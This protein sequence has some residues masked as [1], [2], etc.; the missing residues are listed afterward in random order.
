MTKKQ[1][2][3][4]VAFGILLVVGIISMLLTK[5]DTVSGEPV[6]LGEEGITKPKV[7]PP[8]D[9]KVP[10]SA[11]KLSEPKAEA[12]A[13]PSGGD[14]KFKTF[15]LVISSNGF[16]PEKIVVKQGDIVHIN[17][18]SNES[19]YDVWFRGY[20]V[21]GVAKPGTT[22]FAEFGA[23]AVGTFPYECKEFC[24]IAKKIQGSF[25]VLP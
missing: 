21:Y 23:S 6:L 19:T 10:P 5:N 2:Y 25:I 11:T 24:P 12:P 1:I 20:D 14:S 4:L 22:K 7:P 3:I 8:Y 13:N 15:D 17:L 16:S 9:L 18:L